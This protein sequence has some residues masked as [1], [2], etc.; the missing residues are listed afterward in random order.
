MSAAVRPFMGLTSAD[1][2]PLCQTPAHISMAAAVPRRACPETDD[3]R[4]FKTS[5]V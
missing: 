2:M 1:A 5:V 3:E 4:K